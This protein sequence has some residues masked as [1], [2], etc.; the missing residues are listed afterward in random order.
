LGS[1]WGFFPS[2]REC[3]VFW[4]RG[5]NV[6]EEKDCDPFWVKDCSA[7]EEKDCDPF[8]EKD[9]DPFWVKGCSDCD[10]ILNEGESGHGSPRH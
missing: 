4:A 5:C 3:S 8:W 1:K 10:H 9:C 2:V 6:C 7:C